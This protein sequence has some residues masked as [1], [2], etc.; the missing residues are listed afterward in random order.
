MLF[1]VFS[2]NELKNLYD[3]LAV[4]HIVGPVSKGCNKNSTALYDFD[5]VYDFEELQLEYSATIHSLKRFILPA[6]ETLCSFTLQKN[7]W[8]KHVELNAYKPI[9]YFGLHACDINALNKL[10]KVLAGKIYPDPYYAAKRNNM[11]IIGVGCTP[12][13]FCFCHS[14]GADSVLHGFDMFLTDLGDSYFAEILSARAFE[15]LSGITCREPGKSEHQRFLEVAQEKMKRFTCHVDT[16]DLT[17]ILDLEF[18]ADVWREWGEKCL[19]CGTCANV[20]PTCYCYGV[21]ENVDLDM[22]HA[23]KTRHLYSC[24]LIDFAEVAGGH[25]FRPHSHDRLKYRYYHKHRGF[26]EA[27]E[28]SLCVGCGRCGNACLANITVP[29]VIASVRGKEGYHG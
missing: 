9:V 26:V 17:K 15:C 18:Q 1:R 25:N 7:N 12:Q 19:S 5:F 16:T 23:A 4:N 22:R 28:E 8:Q 21:E 3:I 20:C 10:D 24:N 27:F 14:M 29:E 11:F 13:P 6:K 2:K